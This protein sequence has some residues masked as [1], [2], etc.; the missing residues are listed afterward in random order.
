MPGRLMVLSSLERVEL[1]NVVLV[2]CRDLPVCPV[3]T[4]TATTAAVESAA[5]CK[6]V[7]GS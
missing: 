6:T 4:F 3:I 1:S 7:R 2:H 5:E